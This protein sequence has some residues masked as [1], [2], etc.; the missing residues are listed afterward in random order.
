MVEIP[1]NSSVPTYAYSLRPEGGGLFGFKMWMCEYSV[2]MHCWYCKNEPFFSEGMNRSRVRKRESESRGGE[3]DRKGGGGWNVSE[4]RGTDMGEG[5]LSS[6]EISWQKLWWIVLTLLPFLTA[7]WGRYFRNDVHSSEVWNPCWKLLFLIL[8][9]L[10]CR[11]EE[12][13]LVVVEERTNICATL[14]FAF[15]F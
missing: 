15:K 3:C 4:W 5:L 11:T 1:L 10:F 14:D 2:Q 7:W 6:F 8:A 12:G 9:V 13:L